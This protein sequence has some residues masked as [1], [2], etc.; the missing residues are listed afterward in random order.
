MSYFLEN[1]GSF[2]GVLSLVIT[3]IGFFIAIRRATQARSAATA[4]KEVSAE[5]RVAISRVLTGV[6]LDRTIVLVEQLKSLQSADNW[7]VSLKFY[8]PLRAMLAEIS[9]RYPEPSAEVRSALQTAIGQVKIMEESVARALIGNRVPRG[10][11][12]IYRILNTIQVQLE[13]IASS[14]R[15]DGLGS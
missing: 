6:D 4:A 14:T 9:G 13:E 12:N 1:W 11:A 7:E 2:V 8:Q 3:I 15:F 5:T 10:Q